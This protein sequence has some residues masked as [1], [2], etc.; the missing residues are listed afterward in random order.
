M[1]WKLPVWLTDKRYFDI[2]VTTNVKFKVDYPLMFLVT[3]SKRQPDISLDY[4]ARPMYH[5]DAMAGYEY[6]SERKNRFD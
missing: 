5:Q 2:S 1:K 6:G 3:T 4:G